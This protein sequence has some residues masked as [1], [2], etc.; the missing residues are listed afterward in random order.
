M[1][2][3]PTRQIRQRQPSE[4]VTTAGLAVPDSAEHRGL[5]GTLAARR[6]SNADLLLVARL[7]RARQSL[8]P[9][10]ARTDLRAA[11]VRAVT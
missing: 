10:V 3:G 4:L 5:L 9:V 1:T 2:L 8:G 6:D 7:D 11:P